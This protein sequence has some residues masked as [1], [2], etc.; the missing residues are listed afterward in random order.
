[1]DARLKPFDIP[2]FGIGARRAGFGHDRID[3]I[4][5]HVDDHIVDRL[6]VHDLRALFID[7]LAL[8]VHDIV[9]LHHLLADLV[10]ARLDLLLCGLDRLRQPFRT[11]RF[12]VFEIRI[13][14]LGEQ[15]IRTED[16]QQ[17]V[18]EAQVEPA[19][20]G[21]ALTAR[22]AA[23]LVV[24][25]AA[26]MAFGAQHEQSARFE[27][28]LPLGS[29]LG[30]DPI[31]F[32]VLLGP[33]LQ[34][35]QLVVDPEIDIAAELD[36]GPAAR[37][38]GG[39]GHR[40][41]APRLRNDMRFAFVLAC[42]EDLVLDAFLSEEFAEH[43]RLFDRHRADQDR[44][45]DGVLLG[46]RLGDGFE[47]VLRVLVELVILVDAR[48]GDVGRDLDHVHLVD[49]PE[50][51][52]FGRRGAGHARQLGIHA[53]IVLEGDRRQRLVLRLDLHAFFGLDR[54]VQ[55]VRPAPA[56]HHAAGELIDDDDLVV[57]HDV[58]GITL[59]HVH[60]AQRLVDVVNHL[61]VLDVVE[62]LGL[63]QAAFDQQ[64]FEL[65]GAI[66]GQLDVAL[67]FVLFVPVL[68]EGLHHLVDRKV[69]VRLVLSRSRNDQ[70]GTRL[71]DQDR[72]DFIDDR[73]IERPL[74]HL[75]AFVLHVVAQVIE[76]ELVVGRIGD[77]RIIRIAPL[78]L[79]DVGHDHPNRQAE[80]LVQAAHPFGVA[81]GEV[82]V[83]RDDVHALALDRIEIGR[84]CGDQRLARGEGFGKD[85]VERLAL[86]QERPELVGL[87]GEFG[88][89]ERLH[90]RL[91]RVDPIDNLAE[92]FDIAVVGRA[93]D[94][95]HDGVEHVGAFE[96]SA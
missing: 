91:Q 92:R 93:K 2:L 69:E 87:R 14:H 40:A 22:T 37:H 36:V 34:F 11:D 1:M 89:A 65:F 15:R 13:H 7:H 86:A 27:H 5:A 21:V 46:N 44:L 84:Q 56:F 6:A 85:V 50:F 32:E 35:A 88:V 38:V 52:R 79:A 10:I 47:L 59:E 63:E 78:L 18:F 66:L 3:C 74:H 68:G 57:L 8:I 39:D 17:V 80:E 16:A 71:V 95:F 53:E 12:A 94:G 28:L 26:F 41:D 31:D 49:V 30:L 24:D 33:V 23:Q 55:A 25:P 9:I 20:P 54:L 62:V 61:R 43:F 96:P 51:G 82:V 64:L 90:L 42:I 76:A 81:R 73:E 67:L 48:N 58:I 45:A 60:R 29:D 4:L 75:P 70:R 19:K 77:I 83:H 72:I